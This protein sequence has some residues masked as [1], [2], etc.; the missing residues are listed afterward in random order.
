MPG[1]CVFYKNDE[2]IFYVGKDGA[3]IRYETFTEADAVAHNAISL[4][5]AERSQVYGYD[6][7]PDAQPITQCLRWFRWTDCIKRLDEVGRG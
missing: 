6:D 7:P 3:P 4:R 1:Y 5:K 2:G